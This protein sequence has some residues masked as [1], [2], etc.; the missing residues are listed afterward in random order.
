MTPFNGEIKREIY[1][2][3]QGIS[4]ISKQYA[5]NMQIHHRVPENALR[6]IGIR[7]N[8]CKANGVALNR[9]DHLLADDIAI[10]EHLFWNGEDFV[11]IEEM[12]PITYRE[13]SNAR[14]ERQGKKR[15]EKHSKK[16][17]R[18]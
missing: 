14:K 12:P 7:G 8:N 2:E 5:R 16:G 6:P 10:H 15:H 11:P 9:E 18:R 3:Q 13:C 17:R 1:E 4:D